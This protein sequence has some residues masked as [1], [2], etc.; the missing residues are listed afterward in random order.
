[1][2]PPA[3]VLRFV[4]SLLAHEPQLRSV[5]ETHILDYEEPLPHVFLGDVARYVVQQIHSDTTEILESPKRILSFLEQSIVT[6]GEEVQELISV[7]F[8]ENLVKHEGVI[9]RLKGMLGPN[10]RKELEAQGF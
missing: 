4:N 10:L 2:T 3:L 7:S 6:E 8:L 5:Y 1:M 9:V